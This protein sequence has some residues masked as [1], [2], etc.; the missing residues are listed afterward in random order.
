METGAITQ[1]VDVAQI[2]LYLFWLFFA[3]LI[4]YL[5]R[6]NHREGYPME[7]GR[8]NGPHQEGWPPVPAAKT[9]T[10]P[11]GHVSTSPDLQR[12]DGQYSATPMHGWNGAPIEP[13]GNPLLAGVGPGAWAAR[14]D[15]PDRDMEGHAKIVPLRTS[16][17]HGVAK[18]DVDPRGLSVYGADG[19]VAGQV[20]DLWVDRMEMMFRYLEVELA[21]GGRRLLPMTFSRIKRDGVYVQALLGAQFADVPQTRSTE[22][23]TLLEEEKICACYGAGTLY[24]TAD[25][26]EPL[27]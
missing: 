19:A 11:D 13:V 23:I 3:G 18:R 16:P 21:S 4:Y 9:F 22:E 17:E 26:Q 10:H 8:P 6:E 27:L 7:S 20:V 2:V 25:R 1:Y 15:V 5:L 24:A 14:A 12:P